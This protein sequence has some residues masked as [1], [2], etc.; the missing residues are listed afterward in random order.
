M[1]SEKAKGKELLIIGL[2]AVVLGLFVLSN[3]KIVDL[4]GKYVPALSPREQV[5]VSLAEKVATDSLGR[6]RVEKLELDNQLL[7]A[8]GALKILENDKRMCTNELSQL[9]K[10]VERLTSHLAQSDRVFD[11][12]LK[13]CN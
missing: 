11:T 4:I 2:L 3:P 9:H 1:L 6:C 5:T 13:Q 12:L 10:D 8:T 7:T